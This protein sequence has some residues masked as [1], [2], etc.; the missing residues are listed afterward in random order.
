ML[1]N[2]RHMRT[3]RLIQTIKAFKYFYFSIILD[4]TLLKARI[5]PG[6]IRYIK[7]T[8]NLLSIVQVFSCSFHLLH[9]YNVEEENWLRTGAYADDDVVEKYMLSLFWTLQT[10]TTV[11]YGTITLTNSLEKLYA[12]VVIII[13]A[14]IYSFIV[15]S[16]S[17]S[18]HN[19]EEKSIKLQNK[20]KVLKQ[21]GSYGN[22]P[23]E[24]VKRI[25][26]F[27]KQ[28]MTINGVASGTSRIP[29]QRCLSELPERLKIEL[30][31]YTHRDI[32][33]KNSFFFGKPL[34]FALNVLSI[35]KE[36]TAPPDYIM[37]KRGDPA[38]EVFIIYSGSIVL[39]SEDW[40]P[41]VK[42]SAGSYFGEIEVLFKE[43]GAH[44]DYHN[45]SY[46]A[47]TEGGAVL[48][49][50]TREQLAKIFKDFKQEEE[51]FRQIAKERRRTIADRAHL[52]SHDAVLSPDLIEKRDKEL[53]FGEN[54]RKK[55]MEKFGTYISY[56]QFM[57]K[58]YEKK[59]DSK[60]FS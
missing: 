4:G 14:T 6:T 54:R 11:G 13:G 57:E 55:L 30:I 27:L 17:S 21:M 15:G 36:I 20:L 46:Y 12:I 56:R 45:R 48:G 25:E 42:Y 32:I 3:M 39:Y 22:L 38:E 47:Y 43:E 34:E 9:Y 10:I 2:M 49:L 1:D 28:N 18:V 58:K 31:Q 60:F 50:I 59:T 23:D 40:I 26:R 41:Y 7:I 52:F 24:L 33:K 51:D 37:Y 8:F 5:Q 53:K 44:G 29:L 35:Q 16:I 19:N